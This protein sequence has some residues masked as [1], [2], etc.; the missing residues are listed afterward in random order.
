MAGLLL[1]RTAA[2]RREIATLIAIG[3]SRPAARQFVVVVA[4][5]SIG[6]ADSPRV[7]AL[8]GI[9]ALRPPGLDRLRDV[10]IDG[11]VLA[12][13]AAVACVWGLLFALTPWLEVSRANLPAVRVRNRARS[14]IVV[15]QIALGTSLVVTAGLLVRTVDALHRVDAGFDL[16]TQALTFRVALPPERYPTALASN[17]FNRG[18]GIAS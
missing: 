3:R 10:S 13:I 15:V 1:A 9:A 16:S 18:T 12:V 7:A 6:A 17:A 11:P 4:D 8:R 2:R 5:C 14:A